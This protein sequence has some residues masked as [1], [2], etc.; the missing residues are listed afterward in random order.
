MLTFRDLEHADAGGSEVHASHVCAELAAAGLD[1][2]LRTGAVPGR[3]AELERRGF[4]VVRRG[5][6]LGVFPSA[7]RDER[8]RRLGP[9]DGIV[10]VFH[11]VPF[12]APVWA[13]RTPQVGVVHHV[14]LGVWHHLLPQPGAA[15]GHLAERLAVPAVYRHR[16]L[17]T[18][19]GSTRREV[20]RH[21][22][23]DAGRIRVAHSGVA[24][25]FTPGGERSPSPL[26]LA[27]ARLMPQK[28]V[29]TLVRAFARARAQVPDA[30]LA[31]VGQG[32]EQ[33]TVEAAIVDA[34]LQHAV[35]LVGYVEEGTLVDWYRRAWVVASASVREGYGLTLTE[36]AAC[37]TPVVATRI[38]GHIDAVDEGMSGLLADDEA[39]LA[40]ALAR[41]LLDGELR[42]R[43]SRGA[44]A[45]AAPFRWERAA[46][47][48]FDALCDDADRRR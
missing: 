34:G 37:G 16:E 7:A 44:L 47:V 8:R 13:P 28:A 23:A 24:P 17:V 22:R 5:G 18:V 11:G 12:F 41:V 15:I 36:A 3:P 25:A 32:P 27:V 14:H 40:D 19:A 10:E 29:P 21:Y 20:I 30:R 39:G 2:T 1:V 33:A 42:E 46:Q 6:R 45:H 31:I 4:R 26:V 43:L 48:I 9:V 38:P 35:Q